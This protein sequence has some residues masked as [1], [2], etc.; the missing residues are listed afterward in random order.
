MNPQ[1]SSGPEHG[2]GH[3]HHRK[4]ARMDMPKKVLIGSLIAATL[5]GGA[6]FGAI[7]LARAEAAGTQAVKAATV[8]APPATLAPNTFSVIAEKVSPAV[9]NIQVEQ[10]AMAGEG[11]ENAPGME[12]PFP[13]FPK[14][15]PFQDFF[16]KFFGENGPMGQLPQQ[17]M[18]QGAPQDTPS[19]QQKMMAMGSGFIIDPEGHVVT[20][21]H[22]AGNADKIT[23]TLNDG[24]KYD[25]KL[26]GRDSKTDLALLKIDADRPLPYV[27]WGDSK[28]AKVGDWVVAVGNPFGLGGSVT[29]GIVSA[30]GRDINAGP[31]DDFLQIDAPINRGNSGGPTFNLQGEV[32]GI[33]TA[34]YSPN[35][36]SVGIG[37]AVPS[38]LAKP[39]IAQLKE[40]G[41]VERGWLGV[42]I[43]RM[44]P[45]IAESLGLEKQR[46]A[47]ISKVEPNS[48]AAKA[49]LKQGDVIV[50]VEGESVGKMRELPRIVADKK[51]GQ[52]TALG[53]W[54]NGDAKTID[55]VIGAMPSE[56]KVAAKGDAPKEP[57]Q[58]SAFGMAL[59]SLTPDLRKRYRI[60]DGIEGVL[61][62]DIKANSPASK[63]GLVP[64]DVIRRV[65]KET[66]SA[67]TDVKH[68]IDAARDRKRKA[69]LILVN[70][71]GNELFFALR[72]RKA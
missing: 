6:T 59:A 15:S 34:I 22:V 51:A 29:A 25:A 46:G 23:V 54:R 33:N 57:Q 41:S 21:D 70:R 31:F 66:V 49:G 62:V 10:S 35:G 19:A 45:E 28:K 20:N 3:R 18:P 38:S 68:G 7:E 64:G 8:L 55:V 36:G 72:L 14:N 9:V 71:R 69:V 5:A 30:R 47:L 26:I 16:E 39:I 63:T 67:P 32:V 37:F 61:V 1:E 11:G 2:R 17:G 50:S 24:S 60:P 42:Q 12:G 53:V 44:T 56:T 65:G 43:Q 58:K 27:P 40:K 52:K 13:G 48:P 4:T